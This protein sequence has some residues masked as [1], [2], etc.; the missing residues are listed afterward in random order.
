MPALR[1]DRATSLHAVASAFSRMMSSWS[2]VTADTT[3]LSVLL[4][5]SLRMLSGCSII[6]ADVTL[7]IAMV[8][9]DRIESRAKGVSEASAAVY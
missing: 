3:L 2:F 8:P 1:T 6:I 7:F 9:L 4:S 5:T